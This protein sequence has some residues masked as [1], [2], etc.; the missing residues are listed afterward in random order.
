MIQRDVTHYITQKI[1]TL[2][3]VLAKISNFY[4]INVI[5]IRDYVSFAV[6]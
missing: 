2:N 3:Y 1:V 5:I 6:R 4:V